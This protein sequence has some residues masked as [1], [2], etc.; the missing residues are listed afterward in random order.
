VNRREDFD[1]LNLDDHPIL[2]DT[3]NS[4]SRYTSA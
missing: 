1:R 2:D 4:F 3:L